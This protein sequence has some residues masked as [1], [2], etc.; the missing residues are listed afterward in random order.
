MG[1]FKTGDN[2]NHNLRILGLLY[3]YFEEANVHDRKLLCK[4]IIILNASIVE[5]V[6]HDF[7]M[8]VRSYT[9]EGVANVTRDITNYIRGKKI[10]KFEKYIVSAEKH[11]LFNANHIGLYQALFEL[12]RLRNRIHIQEIKHFNPDESNVFTEKK[13]ILS[14]KCLEL[15]M[16]MME[17]KFPR[18]GR[19]YVDDFEL[20]WNGYWVITQEEMGTGTNKSQ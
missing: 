6:L 8:R 10:S 1:S 14:E 12:C 3:R 2:I 7:H 18:Q 17:A 19:R 13:K 16:K 5:A 20:P 9:A 15:V 4:P 11:D